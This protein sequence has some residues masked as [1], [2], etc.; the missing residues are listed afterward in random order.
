[1]ISMVIFV[2][3]GIDVGLGVAFG[4]AFGATFGVALGVGVGKRDEK[5]NEYVMVKC[6]RAGEVVMAPVPVARG[7]PVFPSSGE[8][9]VRVKVASW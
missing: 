7:V 5:S 4:V 6:V 8:E 2:G 9:T 3:N 1:M